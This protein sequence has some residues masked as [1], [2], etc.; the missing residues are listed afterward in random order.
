MNQ[1]AEGCTSNLELA[2]SISLGEFG[3]MHGALFA[4]FV[5]AVRAPCPLDQPHEEAIEISC[6]WHHR[7]G[8]L[9]P[10]EGL[11]CGVPWGGVASAFFVHSIPRLAMTVYIGAGTVLR[12]AAICGVAPAYDVGR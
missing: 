2:G 1:L 5:G 7:E 3:H 4:G 6:Q 12:L 8:A 11:L 10:L 9:A